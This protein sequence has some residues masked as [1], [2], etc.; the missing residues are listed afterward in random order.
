MGYKSLTMILYLTVYLTKQL[1]V[2]IK[3][4]VFFTFTILLNLISE[5]CSFSDPRLKKDNNKINGT[6]ISSF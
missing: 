5:Y 1:L 3:S 4:N 2:T 6:G